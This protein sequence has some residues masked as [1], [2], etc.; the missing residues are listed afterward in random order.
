LA[1]DSIGIDPPSAT[2]LAH[3]DPR[4]YLISLQT[5]S[6]SKDVSEDPGISRRT[7]TS[8]LP[9]EQIPEGLDLHNICLPVKAGSSEVQKL[10]NIIAHCDSYT[11]RGDKP[12][13]SLLT[14]VTAFV[15]SWNE[16]LSMIVSRRYKMQDT[17]QPLDLR[18]DISTAIADFE[19][20]FRA[21]ESQ[22]A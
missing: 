1:A 19:K 12:E 6:L 14:D 15:P 8:R 10:S 16:R 9:L 18:I 2:T 21:T 13:P 3:G 4:A 22:F 5:N 17:S 20:Q 7:R 11:R